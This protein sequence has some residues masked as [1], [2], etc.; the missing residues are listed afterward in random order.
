[1]TTLLCVP[2]LVE[3]I[4]EALRDAE[5]AR[6][7]GA[8]LIE[9][10]VDQLVPG[11]VSDTAIDQVKTLV[12]KSPLACIVTCRRSEEGGSFDGPESGRRA[13]V[14]ALLEMDQPPRYVDLELAFLDGP[15]GPASAWSDRVPETGLIASTH[16]FD[17]RPASLMRT[18]ASMR[19]DERPRIQ[20]IAY[21]ARSLRDNLELFDLLREADRPMIALAMGEF[22]LMSRL[23]A[24]KFGGFLTFASLRETEATAPGQ[25]TIEE[26][27]GLYRFRSVRPSTRV[28]GVAGWPVAQ[29]KSPLVHNGGFDAIGHDGLYVPLPVPEEWEHFKATMSALLDSTSLDFGGCSVTVPHKTHLVRLARER[30]EAGEP[31]WS[32]DAVSNACGAANTLVVRGGTYEVR[33]TDGSGAVGA[34]TDALGSLS[35]LRIAVVG[36]GGVGR[37]IAAAVLDAGAEV[38]LMNRTA[39][40]AESVAAELGTALD[41]SDRILGTGLGAV[42]TWACDAYVQC[43]SVGMTGGPAPDAAPFDA[44][45]ARAVSGNAAMFET[46]Y[47]PLDTPLM[48]AARAEG[49]RLINGLDLFVRQAETQFRLWTGSDAPPGLFERLCVESAAK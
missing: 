10:R 42:A 37:A 35:G 19:E 47:T 36:A 9:W 13:L 1:M 7:A 5:D 6:D 22:G 23:L 45:V 3:K 48:H 15:D 8:D 31:G 39:E 27:T 32:I 38:C 44:S 4:P 29:S 21:R 20:K 34:L 28:Y 11:A 41:A 43:T 16:D 18:I 49:M 17:G 12:E 2:I 24:P 26:L 33:N 46:V 14:D 40:T 25:P 30:M